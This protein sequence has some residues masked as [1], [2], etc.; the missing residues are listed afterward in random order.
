MALDT[1]NMESEIATF[2]KTRMD[3]LTGIFI[4]KLRFLSIK[5]LL[6]K[7]GYKF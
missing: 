6:L 7:L 4:N 3:E 1:C 2:I 5:L